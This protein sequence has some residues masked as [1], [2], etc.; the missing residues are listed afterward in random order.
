MMD[1]ANVDLLGMDNIDEI[2]QNVF[3]ELNT[4]DDAVIIE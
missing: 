3:E 2:E 1:L 4:D